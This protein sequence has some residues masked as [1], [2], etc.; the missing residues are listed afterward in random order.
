MVP[1]HVSSA[2]RFWVFCLALLVIFCL[3]PAS[4][5]QVSTTGKITGVVTDSSGADV[6]NATVTVKSTSLMSPR[7][8][9]S[10]SDGSY[11]FDLLPPG[12]YELIVTATGFRALN[13]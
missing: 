7:T 10:Q 13:E 6:P 5:S 3:A 1:S 2:R 9:T 4:W 11:L 8:V 12:T